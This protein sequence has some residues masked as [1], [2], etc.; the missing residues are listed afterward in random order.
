MNKITIDK[1]ILTNYSDDSISINNNIIHFLKNGEYNIEYNNC[2]NLNLEY[3]IEDN[4]TIKLFIYSA[5]NNIE[6]FDRFI[7]ND[8]SNLLLFKFYNNNS[9]KENITIDLNG[10]YSRINYSFSNICNNNE[11]YN[12]TINH[13]QSNVQSYINNR[14]ISLDKSKIIYN[15]DSVLPKGNIDCIMDQTTKIFK[16]G[17]SAA[18]VNPNMYIEETDVEAS[19]GSVIGK[20]SDDDIFY[21]TSRGIPETEATKLLIK[22]FILSNLLPDENTQNKILDIINKNWR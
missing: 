18:K 17:Q 19:H 1:N 14:C 4:V 10:K 16:M 8:H 6:V 22:G 7:L 9:V 15:I 2:N 13:N 12:I 20:F 3:N 5:D 11:E 21:L